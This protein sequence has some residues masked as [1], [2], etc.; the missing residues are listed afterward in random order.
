MD[1]T[2]RREGSELG[3]DVRI[4]D[5]WVE[6]A[7]T[8]RG[9][10]A[11]QRA[12]HLARIGWLASLLER[13]PE[14]QVPSWRVAQAGD[15][16]V[17]TLESAEGLPIA[18]RILACAAL[19]R[20]VTDAVRA[21]PSGAGEV[22]S[23]RTPLGGET[24]PW[25]W[26]GGWRREEGEIHAQA[27]AELVAS[28]PG[29]WAW[30]GGKARLGRARLSTR[31]AEWED[32]ALHL[33]GGVSC[34]AV[35]VPD[36]QAARR[37]SDGEVLGAAIAKIT[38][39]ERYRQWR[40]PRQVDD[41]TVEFAVALDAGKTLEHG[42]AA[43]LV[44]PQCTVR[45]RTYNAEH[46]A[47]VDDGNVP[48]LV[49]RTAPAALETTWVRL[50][51]M[52]TLCTLLE[53]LGGSKA[54][55][56]IAVLHATYPKAGAPQLLLS[57]LVCDDAAVDAVE[58]TLRG[59]GSAR[60]LAPKRLDRDVWSLSVHLDGRPATAYAGVIA[61]ADEQARWRDAEAAEALLR[62]RVREGVGKVI[63]H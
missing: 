18:V 60:W 57:I 3:V 15:E 35:V 21:G 11:A 39:A 29:A 20:V 14:H 63:R 7:V 58:A 38:H 23:A 48:H 17:L 61:D 9:M 24:G 62:R 44:G 54:P 16:A 31:E 43:R 42:L 53:R 25:L 37:L 59:I 2:P 1:G 13:A 33:E 51:L 50:G 45:V 19:L 47:A 41:D 30:P 56:D 52:R 12:R 22:W 5:G 36:A 28:V 32:G 10:D 40:R 27:L 49:V 55:P 6:A 8:L 4:G 46:G 26:V 34:A